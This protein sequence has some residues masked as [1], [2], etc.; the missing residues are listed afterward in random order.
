M[1]DVTL[2]MRDRMILV[3]QYRILEKVDPK[4]ASSYKRAITILEQ[5]F[6]FD[7]DS[8][9]G[10]IDRNTVS[11]AKC[12]EVYEILEMYR[13]LHDSCEQLEDKSGIEERK[14]KFPGFDGNN[15]SEYLAYGHFLNGQGKYEESPMLNSHMPSIDMYRRML[16]AFKPLK[17]K[18]PPLSKADI[19]AILAEQIHPSRR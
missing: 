8:I 19:Q 6:E 15:E 2:D 14:V 5:G 9:D 16:I 12:R 11:V 1:A 17:S 4:N 3:N 18:E 13:R 10:S 7:Y